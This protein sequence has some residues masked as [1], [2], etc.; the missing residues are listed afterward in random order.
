MQR[1][2]YVTGCKSAKGYYKLCMYVRTCKFHTC[3][4]VHVHVYM[5]VTCVH[6]CDMCTCACVHVCDMCTCVWH[7]S[8]LGIN[9]GWLN[10]VCAHSVIDW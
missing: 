9:V 6:V 3:A 7:V 10:I 4:C 8:M 5:C 1:L 2:S